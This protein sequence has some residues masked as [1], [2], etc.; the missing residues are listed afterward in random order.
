MWTTSSQWWRGRRDNSSWSTFTQHGQIKFTM[1]GRERWVATIFHHQIFQGINTGRSCDKCIIV[2]QH[3]HTNRY[4]Q[5]TSH[6]PTSVESGV[7]DCL[8]QRATTVPSNDELLERVRQDQ[9]SHGPKLSEALCGE[10]TS[11]RTGV[12]SWRC[13]YQDRFV[14]GLSQQIKRIART[15]GIRCAFFVPSTTNPLHCVKDKLAQELATH[16]IYS[17]KCKTC[18]EEDVGE[19]P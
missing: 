1:K 18:G 12:R 16:S 10:R 15:A 14:S 7:I 13:H 19:T 9:G 8:V 2:N 17:V 4:V 3:T 11:E 5:F 6:H